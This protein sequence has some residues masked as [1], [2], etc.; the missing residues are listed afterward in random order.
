[1]G[2]QVSDKIHMLDDIQSLNLDFCFMGTHTLK[3]E[4]KDVH[5]FSEAKWWMVSGLFC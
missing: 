2:C 4:D 3:E 1:M 5:N